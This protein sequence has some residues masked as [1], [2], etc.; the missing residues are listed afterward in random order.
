MNFGWSGTAD[1]DAGLFVISCENF[2]NDST[3]TAMQEP[4][5]FQY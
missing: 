3:E 1:I 4:V 2:G 5:W